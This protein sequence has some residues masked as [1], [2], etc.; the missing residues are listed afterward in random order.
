[1]AVYV[2]RSRYPYGRRLMCHMLADT[3]TELHEMARKIGKPRSRYQRRASTPH[4]DVDVE[5][6]RLAVANGAIEIGR[7]KTVELIRFIRSNPDKFYSRT[8]KE[9]QAAFDF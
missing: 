7:M 8:P 4:Y 1:M 3:E 6:R 5:E 2:D 9:A